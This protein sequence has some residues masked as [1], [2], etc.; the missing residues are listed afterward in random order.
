MTALIDALGA[1][2]GI[3]CAVGAGGKKSVL[4]QLAREHCG[5]FALTATVHTTT[6][7]DDLPV[8]PVIDDDTALHDC[9]LS[10]DA[11]RSVAYA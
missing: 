5:R 10:V 7:P 1:H 4:Y 2:S 11:K 3:V 8:E 6:F 9:V